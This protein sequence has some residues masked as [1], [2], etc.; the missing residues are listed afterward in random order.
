MQAQWK[1]GYTKVVPNEERIE[2]YVKSVNKV[3][4]GPDGLV[5]FGIKVYLEKTY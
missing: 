1:C 3:D 4:I 2:A 5:L